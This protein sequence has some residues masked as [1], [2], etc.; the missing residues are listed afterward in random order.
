[1]SS[2]Y[3]TVND[4]K[5]YTIKGGVNYSSKKGTPETLNIFEK[6]GPENKQ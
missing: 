5:D 4:N 2:Y 1:L 6:G 3:Y